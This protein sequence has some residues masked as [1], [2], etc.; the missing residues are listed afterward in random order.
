MFISLGPRMAARKIAKVSAGSAS[1]ESVTRMI[2]WSTHLPVYPERM[3]SVVPMV[4]ATTTAR[5]P[6]TIDTRAPKI[7]R[8]ST[9]R[10][11]WSV[12]SRNCEVPPCCHAGGLKRM[13]RL[14]TSG[15]WGASA[16]AK[17]AT[18]AIVHRIPTGNQGKS[19]I[20]RVDSVHPKVAVATRLAMATL[21]DG[22]ADRSPRRARRRRG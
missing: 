14:P 1:Q 13:P 5:M 20:R 4:P 2:S 6:T 15:E 11:R 18:A 17:I 9:S 16:S 21:P 8:E 7:S 3:P 19:F 12:P 10:P 22:Y